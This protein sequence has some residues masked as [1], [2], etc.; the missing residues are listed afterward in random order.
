MQRQRMTLGQIQEHYPGAARFV[1]LMEVYPLWDAVLASG[2]GP[3]ALVSGL[4]KNFRDREARGDT[5]S[6]EI[7]SQLTHP[8]A[9]KYVRARLG[10]M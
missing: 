5:L 4:V 3:D 6:T 7:L 2:M 8:D 10:C 9:M 1:E